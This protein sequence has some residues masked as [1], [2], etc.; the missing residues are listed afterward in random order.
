[1]TIPETITAIEDEFRSAPDWEERYA[2]IIAMG[3]QLAPF[4]E[5]FR[6]DDFRVKGCQSQVWLHPSIENGI[7]RF[8]ADSD[9]IIVKGL[10]AL[11][12]R[13]FSGHSPKEILEA[14]SD[15]VS[16]LGL[17]QHLSQN[18]ANGLAGMLKQ[19]KLYAL[20]YSM[21]KPT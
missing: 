8:E 13:I 3:K 20:A 6:N 2:L 1:M 12:V 16:R 19:V 11:L 7:V 4:P 9:A 5:E 15:F 18:R 21:V 17:D 10:V 14:P